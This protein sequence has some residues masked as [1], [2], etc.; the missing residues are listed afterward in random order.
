MIT[1]FAA[2]SC[3]SQLY[4]VLYVCFLIFVKFSCFPCTF[5]T[6]AV[7]CVRHAADYEKLREK[8]LYIV[9]SILFMVKSTR[10]KKKTWERLEVCAKYSS[11]SGE[12]FEKKHHA[13]I[14][15][16]RFHI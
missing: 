4:Y 1:Q 12:G 3:T 7:Y 10:L 9:Y 14:F 5:S 2:C 8:Q 15:F 6:L 11:E 16:A 13:L